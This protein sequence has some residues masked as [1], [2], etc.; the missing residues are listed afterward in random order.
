MLLL[1]PL[2]RF[3][4]AALGST[5]V[6]LSWQSFGFHGGGESVRLLVLSAG[7]AAA[8]E[9]CG[10][11]IVLAADLADAGAIADVGAI[12]DNGAI[13]D[14]G[15]NHSSLAAMPRDCSMRLPERSEALGV[16]SDDDETKM[17][18]IESA[19]ALAEQQGW[20]PLYCLQC[21][22]NCSHFQTQSPPILQTIPT[23]FRI[24]RLKTRTTRI[25]LV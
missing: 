15:S 23:I 25:E 12:A 21:L 8:C 18:S 24:Y 9:D 4:H 22:V 19:G 11:S 10:G 7:G 17:Q 1:L 6:V 14:V 3:L 13:A 2:L 5:P 16:S 20:Q